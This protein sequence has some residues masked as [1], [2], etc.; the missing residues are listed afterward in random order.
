MLWFSMYRAIEA[1][2][3]GSFLETRTGVTNRSSDLL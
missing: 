2:H 3:P 1:V